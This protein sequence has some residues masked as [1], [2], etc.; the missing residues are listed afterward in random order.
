[1]ESPFGCVTIAVYPGSCGE[2]GLES[3]ELV[4]HWIEQA[5]QG[6]REAAE[7]L[8]NRYFQSLVHQACAR[9]MGSS[10]RAGDEEDIALSAFDSVYRGLETKCFPNLK[11][12]G[13]LWGLLFRK[14][15]RK[16]LNWD[17]HE[18]LRHPPLSDDDVLRLFYD[19]LAAREPAAAD[20]AA[21]VEDL[22][23]LMESL[24]DSADVPLRRIARLLLDGKSRDEIADAL[25]C[26]NAEV[27]RWWDMI[28]NRW[29]KAT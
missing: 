25:G 18:A 4:S 16:A 22:R 1:M 6:N 10:R 23:R 24:P 8:L 21:F 11:D 27:K 26:T 9:L 5:K 2:T 12:R 13:S 17:K 15:V 28:Y 20:A 14:T 3:S 19:R 7:H 29:R